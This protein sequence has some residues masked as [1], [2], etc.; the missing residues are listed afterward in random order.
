[1]SR[2]LTLGIL[3]GSQALASCAQT[4]LV[5]IER[6]VD[7]S[8]DA[9]EC[10][11]Q[12][13]PSTGVFCEGDGF[14]VTSGDSCG[15]QG[16]MRAH[17]YAVCSCS[18]YTAGGSLLVDAFRGTPGIVVAGAGDIGVNGDFNAG[19]QVNISG[20]LRLSGSVTND[21]SQ[22]VNIGVDVEQSDIPPCDCA[23]EDLPFEARIAELRSQN[24]NAVIGLDPRALDGVQGDQ[25]LGLPCGRYFLTRVAASGAVRLDVSGRVE[26]IVESNIELDSAFEISV[27]AGG[28]LELFVGGNM[29][30]VGTMMLGDIARGQSS[31]RLHVAGT[32]SL[33]LQG[34]STIAGVLDAPRA[35]LVTGESLTV[36]GAILVR[37]A[38]PDAKLTVHY[39]VELAEAPGCGG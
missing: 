17:H 29:R 32:G 22:S 19:G 16:S 21:P 33:N 25:T 31:L 36:Y 24:D 38:A 6:A 23:N 13:C 11:V 9:C 8:G 1:M 28:Q 37:R 18:D 30:V 15:E 26:L 27:A 3:V 5:A 14:S 39:D 10:S 4:D 7:C 20:A 2:W 34:T 35:E 12:L